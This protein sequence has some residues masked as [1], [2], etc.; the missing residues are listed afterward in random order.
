MLIIA[1]GCHKGPL[2][3][4]L[5]DWKV[6][7]NPVLC[8][9]D[10]VYRLSA[11][12]PWMKIKDRDDTC[13]LYSYTCLRECILYVRGYFPLRSEYYTSRQRTPLCF[14]PAQSYNLSRLSCKKLASFICFTWSADLCIIGILTNIPKSQPWTEMMNNSG[15]SN[16]TYGLYCTR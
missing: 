14:L 6:Q 9:R 5:F 3:A 8:Q 7:I 10:S 12:I 13:F 2:W 15:P 11:L 16:G 1:K 4:T